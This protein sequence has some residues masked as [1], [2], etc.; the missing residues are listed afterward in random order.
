MKNLIMTT[1]AVKAPKFRWLLNWLDVLAIA[2]WGVL[3]LRYWLTGKLGLLVHPNYFGLIIATGFVL[4]V[5]AAFKTKEL[6]RK[7]ELPKV[8][9]LTVFPVGWSSGLLLMTALVG[10]VVTP[11][12]LTSTAAV[13]LGLADSFISTRTQPQAFRTSVRSEEKS[14]VDWARTLQVYP[15][16]EAYIGRKVKVQ[17]FVVHLAEL[18]DNFLTITRFVIAHC[19]LDAYPVGLPVQLS[20]SRKVYPSDT[21]LEIE[22]QMITTDLEGKRQLTIQEKSIKLIPAPQN[23]YEY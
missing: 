21:W 12:P 8:Q 1:Q 13:Q 9:H 11:H 14:L 17:G 5:I 23:P 18:P 20:Q 19:A 10:L 22:G 7:L 4:L 16:P 2:A 15:E 3:L 6:L